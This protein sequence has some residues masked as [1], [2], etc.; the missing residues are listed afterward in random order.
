MSGE[1]Q[2]LE[3]S[4]GDRQLLEMLKAME[5]TLVVETGKVR[6]MIRY[7]QTGETEGLLDDDPRDPGAPDAPQEGHA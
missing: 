6:R 1:A 3:R 7:V 4:G 2:T 5:Q